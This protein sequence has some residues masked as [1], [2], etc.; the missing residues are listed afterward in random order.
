MATQPASATGGSSGKPC[1]HPFISVF[2]IDKILNQIFSLDKLD[3]SDYYYGKSIFR[4]L[5]VRYHGL[6]HPTSLSRFARHAF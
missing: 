1:R 4:T 2:S 3:I 5:P 6:M